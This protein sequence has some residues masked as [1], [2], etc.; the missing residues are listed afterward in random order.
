MKSWQTGA[1]FI[2]D[3][4]SLITA[5]KK[6]PFTI[7][8]SIPNPTSLLQMSLGNFGVTLLLI[9]VRT[10]ARTR[11]IDTA[12]LKSNHLGGLQKGPRYTR[13]PLYPFFFP[14]IG[15]FYLNG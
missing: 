7:Y 2:Q 11:N 1:A 5:V 10:R 15:K 13:G 6:N 4:L 8:L 12:D 9:C 3:L 14:I